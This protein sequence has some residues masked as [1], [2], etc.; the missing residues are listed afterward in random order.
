MIFYLHSIVHFILMILLFLIMLLR[1][2]RFHSSRSLFHTIFR[3]FRQLFRF[4]CC[5]IKKLIISRAS[6]CAKWGARWGSLYSLSKTP[7]YCLRSI[8]NF[9]LFLL[10]FLSWIKQKAKKKLIVN[11]LFRLAKRNEKSLC[12]YCSRIFILSVFV[13][14]NKSYLTIQ[15]KK[16]STQAESFGF[17]ICKFVNFIN[18]LWINFQFIRHSSSIN[19]VQLGNRNDRKNSFTYSLQFTMDGK[20]T[21]DDS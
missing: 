3:Q 5:Y 4:G 12:L 15:W 1:G 2:L 8:C 16:L 21:D 20:M 10:D 9:F 14:N 17:A 6:S 7:F 11:L 13:N 19:N 18:G